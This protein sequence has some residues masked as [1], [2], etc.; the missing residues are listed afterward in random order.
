MLLNYDNEWIVVEPE[1]PKGFLN[2][3]RRGK[4]PSVDDSIRENANLAFA[5]A[6]LRMK[7]D[8]NPGTAKIEADRIEMKHEL[9]AR[10]NEDS[11][12]A[13]GLP[14]LVHLNLNADVSGVFGS[15][16]FRLKFE[17]S[18]FGQ[19][20]Y[21]KRVGAILQTQ[22]GDRRI[23]LWILNA[24]EVANTLEQ[25]DS[26]SQQWESLARFRQAIDPTAE[27][28]TESSSVNV[29]MT[30]FLT[31]LEIRLA[32]SFS[33]SPKQNDENPELLDFDP[34]PYSHASL[35]AKS[36]D[37][38]SEADSEL[39]SESLARFQDRLKERGSLPA[40]RVGN[41]SYLVIE[42]QA[43]TVLDVM[44]KMQRASPQ[45]RDEF[46]R[47]P[48]LVISAAIEK[49]L[50]ESG[51]L[52]D[53]TPE[54]EAEAIE[55]ASEPMFIESLEYSSRVTGKTK[56]K[57]P[58]IGLSDSETTTWMSLEFTEEDAKSIEAIEAMDNEALTSLQEKL[59]TAFEEGAKDISVG[60]VD[61]AVSKNMLDLV[62]GLIEKNKAKDEE[63][64]ETKGDESDE[65]PYAP[66][67]LDTK[68][69]LATLKWQPEWTSRGESL[70]SGVPDG[71]TTTLKEY[72]VD[73]LDWFRK[74][75]T[76]GLPG[77]LNADEQ[78]LGKTIQTLAFL[79]LLQDTMSNGDANDGP[80]LIVSPTSLLLNWEEEVGL[81]LDSRGLG[82][83]IR[84]YGSALG[85]HKKQGAEGI[86]TQSGEAQLD[87]SR[88]LNAC[89]EGK[90]HRFWL[91]TT[92]TTLSNYQHS[93]ANI[94]FS[95]AVF[96][97]IQA[98]KNPGV[99]RSYAARSVNADFRIGLTGTP[100]E[101]RTSDLWAILDQLAPS[102]LDTLQQFNLRYAKPDEKNME[103]L[104]QLVFNG[105]DTKPSIALRRTKAEVA[106]QLPKKE[107]RLHPRVMPEKQVSAYD[108]AKVDLRGGRGILKA[109]H[110]M[111]TVSV[112]PEF[113]IRRENPDYIQASARL[114]ATFD[115]IREIKRKQERVLV[116]IEHRLV[117]YKIAELVRIEFGLPR[118]NIINGDTPIPQ[119]QEIVNHFQRHLSKDGGFDLLILGTRAA[120]TGLTLT[121]ATH[122][123][124]VSRWWNP[125]VEE[126]CNDR[127][128]R[129]G[130]DHLVTIHVPMAIHPDLQEQS[131]DCLLHNLMN[132]KRKLA[133]S[134]LWPMGD[135]MADVQS[136]QRDLSETKSTRGESTRETSDVVRSAML[137]M[138]RRDDLPDP[139][140]D[141]DGSLRYD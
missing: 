1:S 125:A 40:Y 60:D 55:R 5:I 107:R 75:W 118:V 68:S 99:L 54:G 9:A 80:V 124:H 58:E 8:E 74:C 44:Q 34:I 10:L 45:E 78:G 4:S 117:Q 48:R 59:A 33:I 83:V 70:P 113:V 110:T 49:K 28:R 84:L 27:K 93:L 47:N 17:W 21:P 135:T 112:H 129:I 106:K 30:E 94:P 96:D 14:P 66:I 111:R 57:A 39:S 104:H 114:E 103:E 88:L 120:G 31:N 23:P 137:A 51:D 138:F 16:D 108:Q 18:R 101:N 77:V 76:A 61:I 85:G 6:E 22:D 42:Q 12:I 62:E 95:V 56:Y 73:G 72:Q 64:T 81:H 24:L 52:D 140:F 15:P 136:L 119:R 90:G 87:F 91:L 131:F 128:H 102:A 92:Y 71:I 43:Q 63:Q 126:Q 116:F 65:K 121:A 26:L 139:V 105:T 37:E 3:L 29:A 133:S 115:V 79:R 35:D 86:D 36:E 69:N 46:V 123:I 19:K 50:R 67:I 13:L 100:I 11:A 38:V 109:L 32:D 97:E 2:F 82:S 41:G 53:L 134:A 20:H 25:G 98:L 127:V 132:R 130:Q 122:V 7:S 89:E 141:S